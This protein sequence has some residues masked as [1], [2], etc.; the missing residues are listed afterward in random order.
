[1]NEAVAEK[2]SKRTYL[3]SRTSASRSI[4]VHSGEIQHSDTRDPLH[5]SVLSSTQTGAPLEDSRKAIMRV[6]DPGPYAK[7]PRGLCV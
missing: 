1:M 3:W 6:R 4:S 2:A 7:K 5:S